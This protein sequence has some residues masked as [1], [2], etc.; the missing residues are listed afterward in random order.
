[1]TRITCCIRPHRLEEVKTALSRIAISGMTVTDVRGS[2]N[3][4]E[5]PSM[6]ASQQILIS[7]PLR[8]QIEVVVP[9]DLVDEVV[10]A[11]I[12]SAQTGEPGDGKIFLERVQEALRIRTSE[13]GDDAV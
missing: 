6:L 5:T 13:R 2:G 3:N 8:S 11:M 1:M 12:A 4:P 7:M 10:H 9:D